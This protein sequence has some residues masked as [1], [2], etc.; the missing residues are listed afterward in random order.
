MNQLEIAAQ[1]RADRLHLLRA[2]LRRR[3]LHGVI[4]PRWD[5]Y[6][7]EYCAPC[8]ERLAWVSGFTGS[9]G[10][11]VIT[12][13]R[14]L[15]FV[16]GRYTVQAR[17]QVSAEHFEFRHLYDEPPDRW[18][19]E[20]AKAGEA[21]GY[22]AA[23]LTPSLHALLADAASQVDVSLRACASNPVDAV[24]IDRPP[25]APA[26]IHPFALERSGERSGTKR[27]RLAQQLKSQRVQWL[28][29]T[30]PDNIAWLLNLRGEDVSYTPV[31]HATALIS[32]AGEIDLCIEQ[33]K[34]VGNPA[35]YDLAEVRLHPPQELFELVRR[36]VASGDRVSI[37]P[38]FSPVGAVEATRDV[39][40]IPVL[41]PDPLTQLKAVKNVTEMAGLRAASRRDSLAWIRFLIWI[42][43]AVP[44]REA[45]EVP[46]TEYEAETVILSF[47]QAVPDFSGPS[48]RTISAADANAAMCHYAAPERGSAPIRR[49]SVYLIDSGG[50]YLDGT[51]DTTR[52]LCFSRASAEV[53][54]ACTLV[55]KGHARLATARF[56][57]GTFGHQIDA[58]AR[59]PLWRH[60]MDYDHG[61]GHGVGHFLSVH[62]HPQRLMKGASPA[63]IEAG[64]TLTNEPGYY[65]AGRY[66]VR[67][68]NLCEVTALPNGFLTL[69]EL[70]LV[71][72]DRG[73]IEPGMLDPI[74][75]E[76][77][78]AYHARVN[79]EMAALLSTAAERQWLAHAT[80]PLHA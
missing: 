17:A 50:Q 35:D 13:D 22:D 72:I 79:E 4:V 63:P 3:N 54:R 19:V 73:L 43:R 52:T 58:F 25:Y 62:E 45:A 21:Y 48:F 60:G 40:G 42:E 68:E 27:E 47:R 56:P 65:E 20:H 39:K 75:L 30:Q 61:T 16:D 51:T 77:L 23:I 38:K 57:R 69:R 6:Q 15:L 28:V 14:A 53:R 26:P 44:E 2:E 18:L 31:P 41:Q 9:W 37:D 7:S 76:W 8:D 32:A 80:R 71:P 74:E 46:V 29:E 66:G 34:L 10:L 12:L 67:I 5:A 1:W 78:N 55:L 11:A 59:E 36:R 64:M 49:D 24:W 70:T 33:R